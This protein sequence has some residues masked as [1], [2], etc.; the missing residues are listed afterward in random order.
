MPLSH[1]SIPSDTYVTSFL[2]CHRLLVSAN[3]WQSG[4]LVGRRKWTGKNETHPSQREEARRQRRNCET[5]MSHR[6]YLIL[7]P[8]LAFYC[9]NLHAHL[10]RP[11]TIPSAKSLLQIRGATSVLLLSPRNCHIKRKLML[12]PQLKILCLLCSTNAMY[13]GGLVAM[14]AR[15]LLI[16]W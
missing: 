4:C 9:H 13:V 12:S 14:C 2:S 10:F 11:P 6:V 3:D 8:P 7:I 15:W 5:L 1:L 16:G